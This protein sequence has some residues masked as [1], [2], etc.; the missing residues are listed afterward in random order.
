MDFPALV[1]NPS[2]NNAS[3]SNSRRRSR[4]AQLMSETTTPSLEELNSR[5]ASLAFSVHRIEDTL[6][7]LLGKTNR[8]VYDIVHQRVLRDYRGAEELGTA[9]TTIPELRSAKDALEEKLDAIEKK[10]HQEY[11]N[12]ALTL[13][14]ISARLAAIE[15]GP[16]DGN[17]RNQDA[18]PSVDVMMGPFSNEFTR[19]GTEDRLLAAQ[20]VLEGDG[21]KV[22]DLQDR[23]GFLRVT[24]MDEDSAHEFVNRV[25]H[26][27]ELNVRGIFTIK[28]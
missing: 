28:P 17:R 4:R 5:F 11:A 19:R 15:E 7:L 22:M 6:S 27:E 12:V 8:H 18:P 21:V 10:R 20:K 16:A 24:F 25:A 1:S 26:D 14:C 23:P 3:S 2:P 13:A 9:L